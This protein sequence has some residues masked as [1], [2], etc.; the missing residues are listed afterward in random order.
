M[1]IMFSKPEHRE[2]IISL[3]KITPAVK[4]FIFTWESWHNWEK[5]PPVVAVNKAGTVTG[6]WAYTY[7]NKRKYINTYYHTVYL[8]YRR[9]GISSLMLEFILQNCDAERM[10][11]KTHFNGEGEK[12]WRGLGFQ[13]FAKNDKQELVWDFDIRNCKSIAGIIDWNRNPDLHQPIPEAEMKKYK[14]LEL[15]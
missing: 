5:Y 14:E 3:A 7:S 10:K 15:L 13:P 6:F 1:N 9:Q 4:D 12:F 11:L 8:I 2:K